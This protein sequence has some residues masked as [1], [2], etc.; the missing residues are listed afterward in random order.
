MRIGDGRI[1]NPERHARLIA[2]IQALGEFQLEHFGHLDP[3]S[4]E[5]KSSH[6]DL[7]SWVDRESEAR[8]GKLLGEL[9][10]EAGI[11]AE[12]GLE[13]R[14]EGDFRW[15]VDPLDGTTN[16]AHEHPFFC[17]SIALMQGTEPVLGVLHAPRLGETWEAAT[18]SGARLN[19]REISVS[20]RGDYRQALFATGF[21]D[22]RRI[23]AEVNLGNL[24]RIL[25]ASRGVRRAGSAA[26]DLAFVAAG[27][28]DGFWE[29]GLNPWDVAA[30]IC[31]IR[32]AGGR[33]SDFHGGDGAVSGRHIAASNG[34]LHDWLLGQLELDPYFE[35]ENPG[36]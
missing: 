13:R 23:R 3:E 14:G 24:D 17:I 12:E 31:L 30:G 6:S 4:L 10:P 15:V 36:A 8:L 29:M 22:R 32:E 19:G 27:R 34:L 26:L 18:G 2:G 21:A 25:H 28:L 33:V 7:V 5:Q 20:R 35:G 9:L 1:W 16:Y 11:L